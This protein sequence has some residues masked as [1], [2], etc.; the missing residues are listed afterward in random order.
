MPQ[1]LAG[2]AV[3]P[4]ASCECCRRLTSEF[5]RTCARFILG[6]FRAVHG[7]PTAHPQDRPNSFSVEIVRNGDIENVQVPLTDYPGAAIFLLTWAQPGILRRRR[8]HRSNTVLSDVQFH[9]IMPRLSDIA[10]RFD[11]LGLSPGTYVYTP[12]GF[13]VVSFAQLIAKISHGF[14]VAEFGAD[15][16]DPYLTPLIRGR[17]RDVP[18]FIGTNR[19]HPSFS[20]GKDHLG[21]FEIIRRGN[22]RYLCCNI[23]LLARFNL[24]VYQA[25]VGRPTSS[26]EK[27]LNELSISQKS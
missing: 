22:R 10:D 6:R 2:T 5:E 12:F 1:F 13:E 17:Y 24:P 19:D 23:Q 18:F 21:S 7:L 26:L 4:K 14:A 16:F 3:L 11:R 15:S 27:R 8:A 9:Y 25:V 20:S